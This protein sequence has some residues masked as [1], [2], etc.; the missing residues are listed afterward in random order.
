AARKVEEYAK[1]LIAGG[2]PFEEL[3]FYYVGPID[4]HNFEHLLPV[5]KNVRD[6]EEPAPIL[7][8]V[9]TQKGR[10]YAPAEEAHDKYHGVSKFDVET[11]V[12]NK[13]KGNAPSYTSV[14]GHALAELGRQDGKICAITA[15]MPS[16]TGLDIFGR[17]HPDRLFDVGIAEQHA[18]TFAAGLACEGLKPFCAIYSTFLQRG[19]DQVM[20]DV[21]L[22]H[23]PVRFVLD[24][25]GLVGADGATHHGAFDLS[26]LA[27]L[28]GIVIMAPSD[29]AELVHMVATQAGIDDLPS[30]L[31]YPRG[32]GVGVEIPALG[33][34]LPIG[35][36]RVVR[37]GSRVA[38][39]SLG[40]RLGEALKAADMLAEQGISATVAD[41]RFAK[42]IDTALLTDLARN[43]E[44]LVTV[45]ENAVGGFAAQVVQYLANQGLMDK[46]LKL[47][48]LCLP[49]RFIEHDTQARQ[50]AEAGLDAAG[51][52]AAVTSA[53]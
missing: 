20:H 38:I 42:P 46:G 8:H 26:F 17:A 27:C 40:T 3:G 34:A 51:I 9:V 37:Q 50:L 13:P 18:V 36:G 53:L 28:P 47:R 14:F 23:L 31:R 29:E 52:V 39:L 10:G 11:G 16:G 25:A 2:T 15:A 19:Y 1:G 4:G 33:T 35:K 44:L 5:L 49:D 12:Q 32:D 22:Q 48:T 30:V 24:R 7:V 43:H 41:A 6:F 21:A 45:E